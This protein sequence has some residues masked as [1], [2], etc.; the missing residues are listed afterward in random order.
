[1]P[2]Y[3]LVRGHNPPL[4]GN[5]WELTAAAGEYDRIVKRG[6]NNDPTK[7][8]WTFWESRIGRLTSVLG[9][10]G[11]FWTLDGI[12]NDNTGANKVSPMA[13][14]AFG[15]CVVF[16]ASTLAHHCVTLSSC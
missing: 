7:L 4:P 11:G 5:N 14:D 3:E 10:E 12:F 8:N 9:E 2:A 15:A 1:M 16:C 6:W 13:Y